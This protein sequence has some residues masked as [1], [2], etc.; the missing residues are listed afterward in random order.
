MSSIAVNA[1]DRNSPSSSFPSRRN[2][3]VSGE[4]RTTSGLRQ[5]TAALASALSAAARQRSTVVATVCAVFGMGFSRYERIVGS[6]VGGV[7]R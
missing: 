2:F 6:W 4:L 7:S 5:A 3:S 1:S